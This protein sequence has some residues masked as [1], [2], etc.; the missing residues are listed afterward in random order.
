M[1]EEDICFA[2]KQKIKQMSLRT[3]IVKMAV[4][5]RKGEKRISPLR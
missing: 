5:G 4:E 2:I 1:Q 3:G